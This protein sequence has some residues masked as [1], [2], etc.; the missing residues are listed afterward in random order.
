MPEPIQLPLGTGEHDGRRQLGDETSLPEEQ[1]G[2]GNQASSL[3]PHTGRLPIH[4]A[5]IYLADNFALSAVEAEEAWGT[6]V[7]IQF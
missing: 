6:S 2:C 3:Q 7:H 1:C 5:L 4:F